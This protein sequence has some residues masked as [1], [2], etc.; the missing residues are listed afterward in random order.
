MIAITGSNGKTIV[1]EWLNEL[2]EAD[3]SI[4]RSPKSYNS[5]TGVPLS[6]WQI[7]EGHEL[8]IFEAGI[9]RRGE[10]EKLEAILKPTIGIFTNIG[11][12]HSEGFSGLAEKAAEKL[13]L[14]EGA[15]VVIC[16]G[17]QRETSEAILKWK[18][19][20]AETGQDIPEII[21]WGREHGNGRGHGNSIWLHTFDS[22]EGATK[23]GFTFGGIEGGIEGEWRTGPSLHRACV[24]RE[25]PALCRR[26]SLADSVGPAGVTGDRRCGWQ[27]LG[28]DRDAARTE[29]RDQ[30]LFH[31][32]RQL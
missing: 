24:G 32:Q 23:V 27:Q 3:Y 9:S 31:H 28:A 6:V 19:E 16:C 20:R 15:E 8:G 2:L 25:C 10:M 18:A 17:D 11:E 21:S 7:E 26:L 5:Q 14:F 4:V 13:K 12:A 1:K 30:S 22:L 29:K